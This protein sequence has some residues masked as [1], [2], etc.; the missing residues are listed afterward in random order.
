MTYQ[1]SRNEQINSVKQGTSLD[2]EIINHFDPRLII[3]VVVDWMTFRFQ[4][5]P[6]S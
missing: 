6:R 2:D 3:G 1:T 5:T 4:N